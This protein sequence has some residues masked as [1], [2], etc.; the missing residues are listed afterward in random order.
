MSKVEQGSVKKVGL[1]KETEVRK[2]P[3]QPSAKQKIA[4][5]NADKSQPAN[6]PSTKGARASS[7][8]TAG[9]KKLFGTLI[10]ATAATVAS[11]SGMALLAIM[12]L[13]TPKLVEYDISGEPMK[14]VFWGGFNMHSKAQ[15]RLLDVDY[16]AYLDE[17]RKEFSICSPYEKI[18]YNNSCQVY[19]FK[20]V[21][22]AF[23]ALYHLATNYRKDIVF[24]VTREK[25]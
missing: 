22:G 8:N 18:D 4:P 21:K 6:V 23:P 15:G 13:P 25:S 14:N 17:D 9:V 11:I 3:G 19:Q 24:P 16:V 5:N 2:R 10:K 20:S 1:L 12:L 7:R